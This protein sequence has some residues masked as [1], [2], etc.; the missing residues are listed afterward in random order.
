MTFIKKNDIPALEESLKVKFRKT[1][2]LEEAITHKSYSI[3]N[4]TALFNERLEFLGDAV[5][6]AVTA[7]YLF[8]QYPMCD[9]GAMSKM[10]SYVVSRKNL[11]VWAKKFGLDGFV[12]ISKAEEQCG[13]RM[14]ESILA[15]TM[16]A[17]I[18]AVFLDRGYPAAHS[19]ICGLL[20]KFD[21]KISDYKSELQ[22]IVQMKYKGLPVYKIV[23]ETGPDHDKTFNI[24]VSI[25]KKSVGIGTGKTKKEAEQ[26]AAAAVLK[27][28]A[29]K[30]GS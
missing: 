4:N 27:K 8:K 22:E 23:G 13:G 5:L 11:F 7:A 19:L 20:E 6:S 25:G 2:L 12:R 14:K 24:S 3:E 29:D 18:G 10:K 28:W 26:N 1:G 9:E 16:E 17:I 30:S 21:I 15:N